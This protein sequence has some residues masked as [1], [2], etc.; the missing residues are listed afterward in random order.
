MNR[1]PLTIGVYAC[2]TCGHCHSEGDPEYEPH[3]TGKVTQLP[4][5]VVADLRQARQ[6]MYARGK[7]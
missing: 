1:L 3:M 7:A 6:I 5:E 4:A 2:P